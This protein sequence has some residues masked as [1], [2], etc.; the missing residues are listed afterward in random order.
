MRTTSMFDDLANRQVPCASKCWADEL[1][2]KQRKARLCGTVE[3]NLATT[4]RTNALREVR[5]RV[6][7]HAK[8]CSSP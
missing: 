3:L 5:N 6:A 1:V 4:M 2:W 8:S 7:T